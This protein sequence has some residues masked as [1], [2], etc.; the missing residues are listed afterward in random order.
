MCG[1]RGFIAPDKLTALFQQDKLPIPLEGSS[2]FVWYY[3]S[4]DCYVKHARWYVA[5]VL[6]VDSGGNYLVNLYEGDR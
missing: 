2:K 5:R 1:I 6:P 3:E 4:S